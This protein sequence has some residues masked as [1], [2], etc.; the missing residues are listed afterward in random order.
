MPSSRH[1]GSRNTL[2][3]S[4]HTSRSSRNRWNLTRKQVHRRSTSTSSRMKVTSLMAWGRKRPQFRMVGSRLSTKSRISSLPKEV[5]SW[6]P[7][8]MTN[9][10]HSLPSNNRISIRPRA[11]SETSHRA[12]SRCESPTVRDANRVRSCSRLML[13]MTG[14]TSRWSTSRTQAWRC[15][16]WTTV[17]FRSLLQS[18]ICMTQ[19]PTHRSVLTDLDGWPDPT[20][21]SRTPASRQTRCRRWTCFSQL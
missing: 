13:I 20:C 8:W 4:H 11:R 1:R 10:P 15:R 3:S 12:S 14:Q 19:R 6:N 21:N 7:P 9:S 16:N 5:V 17:I 18:P 2:K